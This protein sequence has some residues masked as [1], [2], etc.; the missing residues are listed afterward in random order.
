MPPEAVIVLV[1]VLAVPLACVLVAIRWRG[2]QH[3]WRPGCALTVADVCTRLRQEQEGA[4]R[5]RLDIPNPVLPRL[6][7]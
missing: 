1:V 2:G 6:A 3:V 5:H 7:G 4:G